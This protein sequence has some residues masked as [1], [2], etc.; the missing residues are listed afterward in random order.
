MALMNPSILAVSFLPGGYDDN[1]YAINPSGMQKWKFTTH[2]VTSSPSISNGGVLHLGSLDS[3]LYAINANGTQ[4]WKF[5]TNGPVTSSPA[6]GNDGTIYV[7]SEDYNLYAI[8][9]NGSQRW[10][11]STGGLIDSSPAIAS[12]GTVYVGSDD[13]NLYAFRFAPAA[14]GDQPQWQPEMEVHYHQ[15]GCVFACDWWRRCHLRG[16]R[17][18]QRLRH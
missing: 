3:N 15:P 2:G 17:R 12:D 4:Q 10:K 8:N 13:D 1:L 6:I 9:P 11:V 14:D 16:L 18:S 7:G 5:T